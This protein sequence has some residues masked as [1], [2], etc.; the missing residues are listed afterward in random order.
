VRVEAEGGQSPQPLDATCDGQVARR[1]LH[2]AKM[3]RKL[4]VVNPANQKLY[5]SLQNTLAGERDVEIIFDRRNPARAARWHGSERRT[6]VD[7]RER[8]RVGGFAVVR[9]APPEQRPGNIRWTA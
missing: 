7:L 9:P 2:D 4:L 1:V 3:A 5:Q 6:G 8:I